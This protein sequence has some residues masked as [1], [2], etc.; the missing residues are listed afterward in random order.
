MIVARVRMTR[1]ER[2][3]QLVT[4]AWSMVREEGA[5]AL[6]LGRLAE[7]AQ[8]TKP[9]V[10]SH[11]PSRS[12]LLVTLYEE[13]D[14]R[15]HAALQDALRGVEESL[16]ACARAIATSHVECVL[17]QGQ[18]LMGVAAALE[19]TPELADVKRRSD[20]QYARRCREILSPFAGDGVVS[21]PALTAMLGAA[22]A[23]AA[24][25]AAGSMSRDEAI[26]ELTAAIESTV[27]RL[28]R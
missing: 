13:Y 26:E 6:T 15:Q 25:A 28:R 22:D 23:L 10:Y 24:S 4:L 18:E 12:A 2:H 9:V 3:A 17:G 16:P 5:N 20:E 21:R 7:F 19:G 27:E 11:F 8:V 1:Q 14:A